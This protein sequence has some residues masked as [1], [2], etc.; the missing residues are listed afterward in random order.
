M[1]NDR[2]HLLVIMVCVV[3]A[4]CCTCTRKD[5][6]LSKIKKAGYITFG[7]SCGYPPFCFYNNKNELSGYDIDVAKEIAKR[8]DVELKLIDTEWNNILFFDN[9]IVN[10]SARIVNYKNPLYWHKLL[11][12]K[13]KS[14]FYK[15]KNLLKEYTLKNSNKMQYKIALLL[16]SK[17]DELN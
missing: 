13:S 3:A 6:S 4:L 12:M 11:K 8:L 2:L 17:I 9:S 14:N 15:Q 5:L 16:Q 7:V 10:K 1:E